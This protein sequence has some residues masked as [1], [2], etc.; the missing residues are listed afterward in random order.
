MLHTLRDMLAPAAMARVTLLLNHVL[1]SEAVATERLRPHS[2]K[3][4][5]IEAVAWPALL[6]ALPP[7][8]WRIT[9]AGL[10][11]WAQA[12]AAEAPA[13]RLSVNADNPALLAARL[14]GGERPTVD[15][16]GDA[17]FAGDVSWLME[18]LR[19][20]IGADLDR[21]FPPPV[22]G[23]L[24]QSGRAVAAALK[25]AVQNLAAWRQRRAS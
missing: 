13:L 14:L 17:Q 24:Q 18:N 16:S 4:L 6:P 9:P 15:V 1:G 8:A 3:L 5:R 2:G 21:L 10:L 25:A 19:W 7:L 22:A 11:D 12:D 23:A 20:D